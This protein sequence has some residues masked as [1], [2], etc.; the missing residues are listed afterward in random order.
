MESLSDYFADFVCLTNDPIVV[1]IGGLPVFIAISVSTAL[2]EILI[3]LQ[4]HEL[5]KFTERSEY[6]RR[7]EGPIMIDC[8][9]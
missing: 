1:L 4:A 7:I 9:I 6:L 3:S 5:E 2:A 8:R